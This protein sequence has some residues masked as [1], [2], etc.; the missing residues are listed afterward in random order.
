MADRIIVVDDEREIA[1]LI[2]LYLEN[3]GYEV[4]KFLNGAD[5]LSFVENAS[6]RSP[7]WT[8]CCR[9]PTALRFCAKCARS[10]IFR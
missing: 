7:F 8:L 2:G 9:I 10:T 6:L 1:D 3:D 4:H 5:A